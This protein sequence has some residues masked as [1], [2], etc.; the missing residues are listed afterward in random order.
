MGKIYTHNNKII[1]LNDVWL[2]EYEA[3]APPPAPFDTVTIGTQVWAKTNLAIDDGGSG[4]TIKENVTYN[5]VNF[6]TQYYY[7]WDAASRIAD[8]IDGWHLPTSEEW[9]ALNSFLGNST[10]GTKLKSTYGWKSNGNGTDDYGFTALP[11]GDLNG[12]NIEYGGQQAHFWSSYEDSSTL[13]S[14]QYFVMYDYP[15][16]VYQSGSKGWPLSVRLIQDT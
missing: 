2:E 5:D 6:G 9:N 14:L 13:N 7:N 3:P 1:T 11:V 16:L 10:A 4:I 15:Y 8:S 12:G